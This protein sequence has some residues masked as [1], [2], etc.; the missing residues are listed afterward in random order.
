MRT[1]NEEKLYGIGGWL[2][3]NYQPS[4]C[5]P[6]PAKHGQYSLRDVRYAAYSCDWWLKRHVLTGDDSDY[7]R[8]L[9]AAARLQDR[10]QYCIEFT[11]KGGVA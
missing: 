11:K 2:D 3:N 6:S 9:D 7:F 10:R 1:V 8:Y 4:P 5:D